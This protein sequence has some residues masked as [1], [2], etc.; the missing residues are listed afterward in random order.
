MIH[1]TEIFTFTLHEPMVVFE[2]TSIDDAIQEM[3]SSN[4]IPISVVRDPKHP[5]MKS[6]VKQLLK[7][8]VKQKIKLIVLSVVHNKVY[9]S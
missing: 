9:E 2:G 7:M 5:L 6:S 1:Y 4:I 8:G 3:L